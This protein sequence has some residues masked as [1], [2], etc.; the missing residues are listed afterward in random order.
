VP[1]VAVTGW[2]WGR[3]PDGI[4]AAALHPVGSVRTFMGGIMT[5]LEHAVERAVDDII[6]AMIATDSDDPTRWRVLEVAANRL[7]K[8][9][10]ELQRNAAPAVA[11]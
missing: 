1:R 8:A 7:R 4:P 5:S 6:V 2:A 10:R 11:R 9:A 3:H